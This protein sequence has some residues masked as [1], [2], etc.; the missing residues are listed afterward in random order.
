MPTASFSRTISLITAAWLLLNAFACML[1]Y[2]ATSAW[3]M[4]ASSRLLDFFLE[5]ACFIDENPD[6]MGRAK[7]VSLSLFKS[8]C[9]INGNLYTVSITTRKAIH[10]I[11]KFRYFALD[12]SS[13]T[14]FNSMH[15]P[16]SATSSGL[17][18]SP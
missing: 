8:V 5:N 17:S 13:K 4:S 11:D 3:R 15:S 16:G 10:N 12:Y 18:F 7:I 9:K 1:R 2:S 14:G 6:Y